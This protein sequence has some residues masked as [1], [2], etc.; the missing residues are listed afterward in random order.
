MLLAL[1]QHACGKRNPGHG[2]S[3]RDPLP[4][5]AQPHRVGPVVTTRRNHRTGETRAINIWPEG[6]AIAFLV[7]LT[8]LFIAM[9]RVYKQGFFKTMI[10]F[11]LLNILYLFVFSIFIFLMFVISALL[12]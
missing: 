6:I 2:V 3:D 12:Y 8:Y 11:F 10:K 7:I 4:R 9:K 1:G 5:L